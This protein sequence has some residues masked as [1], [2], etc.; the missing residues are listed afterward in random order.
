LRWLWSDKLRQAQ[1]R[2]ILPVQ[3]DPSMK[4]FFNASFI[5]E[6]GNGTSTLF[7]TDPWL[8]GRSL[9]AALRELVEVVPGRRRN[10]RTV[11]SALQDHDRIVWK[12]CP[13]G[14]YS[15]SS[16]YQALFLGQSALLGAKELWKVK[17]P[18][19]FRFFFWLA[20]QDRC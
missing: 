9:M 17:A 16:A 14:Q 1:N 19:E 12:W 20:I 8:N 3:T 5:Y 7:W 18:N 4:A 11:A 6:V 10:I 2:S 13:S 15:C